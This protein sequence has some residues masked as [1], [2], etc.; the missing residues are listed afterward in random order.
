M[1]PSLFTTNTSLAATF[2]NTTDASVSDAEVPS[3]VTKVL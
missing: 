2:T 1:V 3:V